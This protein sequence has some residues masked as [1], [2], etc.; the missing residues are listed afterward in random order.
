[1]FTK[2]LTHVAIPVRHRHPWARIV[3]AKTAN[4]V[5]LNDDRK[6]RL[7][8]MEAARRYKAAGLAD[9][10][11]HEVLAAYQAHERL[12]FWSRQA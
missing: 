3:P 7:G 4:A 8:H 9:W 11:K 10:A 1:M 5:A 12:M 2:S 6:A